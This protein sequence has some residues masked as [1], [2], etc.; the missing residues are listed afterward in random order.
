VVLQL[1]VCLSV[2][3]VMGQASRPAL[4]APPAEK[5]PENPCAGRGT[6]LFL[7]ASAHRLWLCREGAVDADYE[8]ALGA[9]GL[10]KRAQRDKKTPLGS[11]GVGK[12]RP[13][14]RYRSFIPIGYP[15]PAQR[16]AGYTGSDIGIHGPDPMFSWEGTVDWTNGC[17]A[18][19][20][21]EDIDALVVWTKHWRPKQIEIVE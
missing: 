21:S 7:R 5:Q 13:S 11:Y 14:A 17:I 18:L 4:S 16:R 19:K 1:A 15:T 10:D 3:L 12:P 20:Q 2:V 8:V 6:S 9:G